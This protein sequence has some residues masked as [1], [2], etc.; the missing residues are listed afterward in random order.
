MKLEGIDKLKSSDKLNEKI[1]LIEELFTKEDYKE[2]YYKLAAILE[3]INTKFIM[4]KLETKLKYTDI[5]TI[6]NIYQD[7][8]KNLF[9]KMIDIND[10]YNMVSENGID[11]DDVSLLA[12]KIDS[13]YE[14]MTKNYGE[15]I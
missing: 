10:Q 1:E 15:F 7:K 12:L 13:I 9:D 14:Y 11:E 2:A 8:E 6:I 5:M 4:E 3:Y